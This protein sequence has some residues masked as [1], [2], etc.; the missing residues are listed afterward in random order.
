MISNITKTLNELFDRNA[1]LERS[2]ESTLVKWSENRENILIKTNTTINV[3]DNLDDKLDVIEVNSQ[4]FSTLKELL[5]I[6]L[7]L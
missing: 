6:Y 1:L 5:S 2:L 4:S 3:L 7:K